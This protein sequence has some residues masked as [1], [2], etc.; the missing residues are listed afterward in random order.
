MKAKTKPWWKEARFIIPGVLVPVIIALIGLI[1]S[2]LPEKTSDELLVSLSID[3]PRR[4]E[5]GR[6]DL[7]LEKSFELEGESASEAPQRIAQSILE[8]LLEE[9]PELKRERETMPVA[10]DQTSEGILRIREPSRDVVTLHLGRFPSFKKLEAFMTA[11]DNARPKDMVQHTLDKPR[12]PTG[13]TDISYLDRKMRAGVYRVILTAPGYH[14]ATRYLELTDE[15]TM[16]TISDNGTVIKQDFPISLKLNPRPRRSFRVA[17]RPCATN[18]PASSNPGIPDIGSSVRTKLDAVFR[19]HG[20]N[21]V[22]VDEKTEVRFDVQES[23]G[24]AVPEGVVSADLIIER[25][26][27]TWLD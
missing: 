18:A 12:L 20:L 24:Y 14:D 1:P 16:L 6:F 4:D 7:S 9:L 19:Q 17:I 11:L 23:K 3:D 8:A 27:C 26:A 5:A 22:L 25:C 15:G 10:L 2:F 13:L 21:T